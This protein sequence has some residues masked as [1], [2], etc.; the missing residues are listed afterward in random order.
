MFNPRQILMT[1]LGIGLLANVASAA[2]VGGLAA[3]PTPDGAM[4]RWYLPGQFIPKGG[5]T[6][7]RSSANGEETIK[8]ASPQPKE[9]ILKN[10]W[11][12]A[13][14]LEFLTKLYSSAPD[15]DNEKLQRAILELQMVANPNMAKA[16]GILY[17]DTGLKS[18]QNYTYR[19][20]ANVNGKETELGKASITTGITPKVPTPTA[21]KAEALPG[22]VHLFWTPPGGYVASYRI[23]RGEGSKALEVQQPS[24]FFPNGAPATD[25][26]R[27]EGGALYTDR[28]LEPGKKYRYAIKAID[29]FGRESIAS[30]TVAID[31]DSALPLS[32]LPITDSSVGDN[33]IT[34]EWEKNLDTR[35]TSILVMRGLDPEKP[36]EIK[37]K[38]PGNATSYTDT[39][40]VGGI[41]YYYAI[42]TQ[43]VD[44]TNSKRGPMRDLRGVNLTQPATPNGLKITPKENALELTWT[45][46]KENDLWGYLV[47]RAESDK[48]PLEKYVVLTGTPLESTKYSDPI[49]QGVQTKYLYRIIAIN[50]SNVRSKASEAVRG[51]V[52][53]KTAPEAPVLLSSSGLEGAI[54]IVWSAAATPD[55]ETFEVYRADP[56]GQVVLVQKLNA[57]AIGYVDRTVIP[58][59]SYTYVVVAVDT[60]GNRSSESNPLTARAFLS[61]APS[62]P[63]A[64]KATVTSAGV[65][66]EWEADERLLYVVYRII[67][68]KPVQ[69]SEAF[70]GS[71]FTDKNG[72][73]GSSYV[74]RA[75]NISGL[76][77]PL[78]AIVI[79][80]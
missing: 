44:G 15:T 33:R 42:I 30:E 65:K 80:K 64:L 14:Q 70:E 62:A 4:L 48:T 22:K 59:T 37:A 29:L 50:T 54:G 6:L 39:D 16:F 47:L 79:S 32:G 56:S 46:A 8:V 18:G 27:P 63:K 49:P 38:L 7:H 35:V 78:S 1:L 75:V 51:A 40:I 71:S 5:F 52:L 21:F 60:S 36:L 34:I 20:T 69:V 67:N 41:H 43:S 13:P 73:P 3:L 10:N 74:V 68:G 12:T 72:K 26:E 57:K 55:L 17:T 28:N 2:K 53:D 58:N 9:V 31:P 66:L 19:V 77:S 76:Q 61:K 11:M 25:G 45:E 24:P 23:L